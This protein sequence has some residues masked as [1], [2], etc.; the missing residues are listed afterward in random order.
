MAAMDTVLEHRV[1]DSV[2]ELNLRRPGPLVQLTRA[3][4]STDETFEIPMHILVQ[5]AKHWIRH[6]PDLDVEKS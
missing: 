6:R 2:Y 5:F 3:D 4:A 1:G